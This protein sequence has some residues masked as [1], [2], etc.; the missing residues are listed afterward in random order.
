MLASVDH[1]TKPNLIQHL[2]VIQDPQP[3]I[4]LL[5]TFLPHFSVTAPL[6]DFKR[7]DTYHSIQ[8][9]QPTTKKLEQDTNPGYGEYTIYDRI[10][11][12]TITLWF[13]A[14]AACMDD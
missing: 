9:A 5:F 10:H 1:I 6:Q 8:M 13:L 14:T 7:I 12:S 4:R 3:S 2:K 11:I